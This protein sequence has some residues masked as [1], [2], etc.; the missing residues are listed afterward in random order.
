MTIFLGTDHA[1]FKLKEVLKEY[2]SKKGYD[3]QD[4]GA[5]TFNESDDYPDFIFPVA[6]KVAEDPRNN[7]GIILGG[8]GQGEAM[9]ANRV[10]D[11]R[12]AV[13]YG[14]NSDI[15]KLAREHNDANVLSLGARFLNESEA[16]EA[17]ELFL[18]TG[19]SAEDR[20]GRRI[21]KLDV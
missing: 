11:V 21:R 9:C 8:S 14:F 12:A 5:T 2:L 16:Q 19:F 4:L 13:Y 6:K 1:G 3:V 7:R 20:H 18:R 10:K 17:V 15:V